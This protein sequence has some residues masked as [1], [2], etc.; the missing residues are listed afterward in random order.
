MDTPDS[1]VVVVSPPARV[2]SAD[3][4]RSRLEGKLGSYRDLAGEQIILFV[5]SDYWTHSTSTMID[6][7]FGSTEIPIVGTTEDGLPRAGQ[8][9]FSGE[10]LLTEDPV[11]GHPGSKLVAGCMFAS[12]QMFNPETGSWNLYVHY[13]HNPF[14]D[15]RLDDG[16]F[17]PIPEFQPRPDG[18]AWTTE[19]SVVLTMP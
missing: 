13:V 5:G 8:P 2:L 19:E 1:L 17:D 9:T 7:L 10:G 16:I 11:Y 12:H 6:A 3:R 14:A 15:L 4:I 18:M